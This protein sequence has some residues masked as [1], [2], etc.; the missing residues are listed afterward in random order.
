MPWE[1]SDA[2][3]HN[4]AADT[5]RKQK[6]WAEVANSTLKHTGDDA[7]AIRAANSVLKHMG[8]KE[9]KASEDSLAPPRPRSQK[10]NLGVGM[11]LH[12]AAKHW[13][14]H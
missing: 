10:S 6:I 1:H 2:L 14:K 13:S 4:H 11:K 8:E 12:S 7:A 5:P 3:K 9:P